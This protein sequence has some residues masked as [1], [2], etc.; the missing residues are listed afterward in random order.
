MTINNYLGVLYDVIYYNVIYL[1][2]ESVRSYLKVYAEKEED[3]FVFYDEFRKGKGAIDPPES[4]YPFFY[5]NLNRPCAL[6]LHFFKY[7]DFFTG[8]YESYFN[9]FQDVGKFKRYMI[10][11]YLEQ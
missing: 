4:L 5:Y 9:M 1:N 6:S 8:T 7:F 2:K 10:F 11:Y 3:V